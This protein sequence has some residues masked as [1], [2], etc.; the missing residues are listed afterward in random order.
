MEGR[1]VRSAVVRLVI[2]SRAI[3]YH[4]DDESPENCST[5]SIRSVQM[6]KKISGTLH[7]GYRHDDFGC[8]CDSWQHMLAGLDSIP[9]I[10]LFAA[11]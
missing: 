8:C 1:R 6:E 11:W 9:A 3:I 5:V 10:A 4:I 2:A 7:A